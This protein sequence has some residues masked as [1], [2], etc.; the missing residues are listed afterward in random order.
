MTV[1][2]PTFNYRVD[3]KLLTSGSIHVEAYAWP[4][5]GN[6]GS[7]MSLYD[8]YPCTVRGYQFAKWRAWRAIERHKRKIKKLESVI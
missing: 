2:I 3:E 4:E 6:Y 5:G 1:K 8:S 7:M